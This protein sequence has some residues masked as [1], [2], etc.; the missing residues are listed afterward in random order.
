MM[1][2]KLLIIKLKAQLVEAFGEEIEDVVLFG[3]RASGEA[4]RYSDY[5]VLI[6]VSR[7]YDWEYKKKIISVVYGLELHYDIFIDTKIISNRELY[8][9]VKGS[10]PLY[11]DAIREGI[12]A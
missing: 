5:D 7:D 6:V 11:S 1:D 12:H 3:S 10:H 2:K 9:T 8:H 4:H